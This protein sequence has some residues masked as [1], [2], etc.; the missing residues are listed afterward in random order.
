MLVLDGDPEF[1]AI[2]KRLHNALH[3]SLTGGQGAGL[4]EHKH[5]EQVLQQNLVDLA[6]QVRARRHRASARPADCRPG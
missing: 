1:F 2:T 3:G 5:Y 4:S 6:A